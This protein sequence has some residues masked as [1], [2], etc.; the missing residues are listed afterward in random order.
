MCVVRERERESVC[1]CVCVCVLPAHLK[2]SGAQEGQKKAVRSPGT[3]VTEGYG[4]LYNC[5]KSNLVPLE[6]QSLTYLFF[7]FKM[8][9]VLTFE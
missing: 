4:P 1:V 8:R 3:G 6:E 5:W 9:M 7:F 2:M